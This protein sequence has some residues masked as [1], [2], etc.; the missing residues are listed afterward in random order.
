MHY[1]IQSKSIISRNNRDNNSNDIT[2]K[3]SWYKPSLTFNQFHGYQI[4]NYLQPYKV[5]FQFDLLS[6]C[7]WKGLMKIKSRFNWYCSLNEPFGWITWTSRGTE[8]NED[9]WHRWIACATNW[10]MSYLFDYHDCSTPIH[11]II[12]WT[13]VVCEYTSAQRFASI[14]ISIHMYIVF[15]NH[16]HCNYL[17]SQKIIT[18][19][20][21]SREIF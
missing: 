16:S 17:I 14:T 3:H 19:S 1:K 21:L 11:K 8:V 18:I 12:V 2:I 13:N 7:S 15:T 9:A 10:W 5:Y 4:K 20:H 6:P